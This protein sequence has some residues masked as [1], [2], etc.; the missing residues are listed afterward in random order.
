MVAG[1]NKAYKKF[2]V[3]NASFSFSYIMLPFTAQLNVCGYVFISNGHKTQ[4]ISYN[5]FKMSMTSK[6]LILLT[7]F[8][9]ELHSK[10]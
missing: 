10:S 6:F 9:R 7:K 2:T 4:L 3:L 5:I 1:E 8:N